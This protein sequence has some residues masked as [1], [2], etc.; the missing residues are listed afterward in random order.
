MQ[1]LSCPIVFEKSWQSGKVPIGWRERS[2][3]HVFEKR[4]ED[5][6]TY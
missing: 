5:A 3:T 4:N 6:G 1:L 2:I